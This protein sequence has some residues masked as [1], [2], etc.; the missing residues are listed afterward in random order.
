MIKIDGL[1]ISKKNKEILNKYRI[2]LTAIK[3]KKVDTT[4]ES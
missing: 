3:L 4:V 1:N 2:E